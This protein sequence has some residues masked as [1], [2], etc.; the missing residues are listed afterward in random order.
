VFG[1]PDGRSQYRQPGQDAGTV[2]VQGS[3]NDNANTRD[4]LLG[5]FAR[6]F[7]GSSSSAS[8]SSSSGY[9][10]PATSSSGDVVLCQPVE[11]VVCQPMG[12]IA[13]QPVEGIACQ[14]VMMV[15]GP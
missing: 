1:F 14:P 15:P 3:T 7:S 5:F 12:G 9:L 10:Q 4:G 8:R 2:M 11:G 13:C 6:M